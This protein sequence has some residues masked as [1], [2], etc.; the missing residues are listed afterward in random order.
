MAFELDDASKLDDC[1]SRMWTLARSAGDRFQTGSLGSSETLANRRKTAL[2]S[3]L[4]SLFGQGGRT[5]KVGDMVQF[6][7]DVDFD[8]H[9]AYV[10]R[11]LDNL[12]KLQLAPLGAAM[13]R[14]LDPSRARVTAFIAS[15]KGIQ[16]GRRSDVTFESP[17]H[18][19]AETTGVDPSEAQR[20]LQ[21]PAELKVC[22]PR[23][24]GGLRPQARRVAGPR[25]LWRLAQGR[26]EQRCPTRHISS[27][28]ATLYRRYRRAGFASR[29]RDPLSFTGG[30]I[31]PAGSTHG[32]DGDVE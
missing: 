8:S 29:S 11:E 7:L 25:Q 32:A 18:D 17:P 21:V 16:D 4:E 14:V 26:E 22:N 10:L 30:D 27:H 2:F 20:P 6:S 19:Y 28:P 12:G 13:M 15:K 31:R 5:D 23:R 3:S 9:D 1:T 24:R